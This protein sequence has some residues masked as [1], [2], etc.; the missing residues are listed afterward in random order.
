MAPGTTKAPNAG[1]LEAAAAGVRP[2]WPGQWQSTDASGSPGLPCCPT[3]NAVYTTS[4]TRALGSMPC[5]A[6]RLG[7]R[8]RKIVPVRILAHEDIGDYAG[9]GLRL[10]LRTPRTEPPDAL[11]RIG[12]RATSM[13]GGDE[14]QRER[15]LTRGPPW[16]RTT[17]AFPGTGPGRLGGRPCLRVARGCS[18]GAGRRRRAAPRRRASVFVGGRPGGWH[19]CPS[20]RK[21]AWAATGEA[22][23][24][25]RSK[26]PGQG[27]KGA[28]AR[29]P[30]PLTPTRSSPGGFAADV[31]Q[32]REE[33][34][35]NSLI[36]S[37]TDGVPRNSYGQGGAQCAVHEVD[38]LDRAQRDHPLIGTRR[39]RRHDRTSP[40]GT[41]AKPPG[42]S[43]RTRSPC[44]SSVDED[45][46]GPWPAA[47]R[48]RAHPPPQ[49]C[50]HAQARVRETGGEDHARGRARSSNTQAT[51]LHPFEQASRKRAR[52]GPSFIR[53]RPGHRVVGRALMT[54]PL[55]SLACG[56]TPITSAVDWCALAPKPLAIAE[57]VR[58]SSK[59][60]RTGCR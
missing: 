31:I 5:F 21:G 49:D 18:Q 52:P 25:G 30:C 15:P 59:T 16:T 47:R 58:P 55:A 13:Q 12:V 20:A 6:A 46:V 42:W 44:G 24:A 19:P 28:T 32:P 29:R 53:A 48:I 14:G 38:G 27:R 1:I 9:R 60:P 54:W 50:G 43:C 57:L 45:R 2:P 4:A 34:P 33:T 37:I 8:S 56:L 23:A 17:S 36:T 3:R 41:T 39:R 35:S 51:A 7:P 26:R 11:G 10:P 22:L 40:A